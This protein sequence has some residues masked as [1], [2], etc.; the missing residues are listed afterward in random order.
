MLVGK[1]DVDQ[2]V[3]LSEDVI[4]RASTNSI[5]QYVLVVIGQAHSADYSPLHD[6]IAEAL[7]NPPVPP[8][9]PSAEPSEPLTSP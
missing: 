4:I 8:P 9:D 7:A 3:E 5:G 2:R 1:L 6:Y